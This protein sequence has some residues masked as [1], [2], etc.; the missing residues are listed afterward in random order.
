MPEYID[1]PKLK[2]ESLHSRAYQEVI[3]ASAKQKNTLCVL[4]TGLGKTAV[5][6][7]LSAHVLNEEPGSKILVLAPTRPLVEQHRESFENSLKTE[8]DIFQVMT[9]KTR[10]KKREKLWREVG[11]FFATPQ[12]V[13]NDIISDRIDLEDFS[14]VVFD[15]CHKASGEYPYSFI[16]ESYIKQRED[17]H[18]LGLTAS[19]GGNME[20][21]EKVVE[22]LHIDDVEV[23]TEE[24]PDVK[25][26]VKKKNVSWKKVPL[27]R[28]FKRAK[29]QFEKAKR[30]HVKK[31]KQ[32]GYMSG[33]GNKGDLL[34]TRGKIQKQLSK[35]KK[36]EHF[37]AISAVASALKADHVLE[38]LESQGVETAY[39]YIQNMRKDPGS[40]AAKRLIDDEDFQNG[41]AV[42]EWMYK[43]DKKH[44]KMKKLRK[45][46][47]DKISGDKNAIVFTQ[48]RDTVDNIKEELEEVEFLEP[49]GFKGQKE[50]FTQKKQIDILERFRDG[51]FNVLVSTS[52]GEEGLDIPAVDLVMFYEPIPSE[53]R[54]IQRR[55]RTGRQEEGYIYVL[56][57]E[58]T[59]DEGYY[60]SSHHKEKRMKAAL[61]QL[62]DRDFQEEDN[63]QSS[64]VEFT[65]QTS[66]KTE[67][68]DEKV[69]IV[70]DDRENRVM[71]EL[72]RKE[73]KVESERLELADFLV[74]DRTAIER[75]SASDFV[76][77]MLD[78]RLFKQLGELKKQFENPVLIIEGKELY[79]HRDV[80]P[81]AI[82]GAV[83]S[84]ALDY[85]IPVVWTSDE[86]ET[87]EYLISMARRE[88]EDQDRS[89]SVRGEMSPNSEKELQ[90]YV[91]SGL[92][93]VSNRLAERLLKHFGTVREVFTADKEELMEVEG[94]GEKKS[95]RISEIIQRDYG[96]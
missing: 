26:Y 51:E 66:E 72:S 79:H 84:L 49:V 93:N 95:E 82:R 9:G 11:A 29:K 38:L 47:E 27:T 73:V 12:V 89:L 21:I 37:Q 30:K 74:S 54:T 69:R 76:D 25:P 24:D 55:G 18:I 35:E 60:W 71:K 4:P 10:P 75:K 62:K 13:E 86:D 36:P 85:Q 94:I 53:I 5:A 88:Q 3:A 2:E 34:K 41:A 46:L 64:V 96:G 20:A 63:G 92:P 61:E 57:A 65:D 40:K 58:D 68:E 17:G 28:N 7:L 43:N 83:S 48:Y 77:S 6:V 8:T 42:V 32:K 44:P 22:N 15:E 67:E 39:D 81:N 78:N 19:P 45:L 33:K 70:A 23:R 31:L 90:E 87:V 91:V 80:H 1:H 59:R 52:V 56:M 50:G 16:A 14:L